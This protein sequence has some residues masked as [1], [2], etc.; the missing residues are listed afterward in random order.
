[1]IHFRPNSKKK[2]KK[3]KG[4]RFTLGR[5]LPSVFFFFSLYISCAHIPSQYSIFSGSNSLGASLK[6]SVLRGRL[7]LA[8][9]MAC[10]ENERDS[11][12]SATPS[13]DPDSVSASA[14]SSRRATEACARGASS[15]RF[16][17]ACTVPTTSSK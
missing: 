11:D 17:A 1:M 12:E 7:R 16:A 13:P 8:S 6:A 3:K 9:T 2:K 15:W 4:K 14:C 5:I 10:D